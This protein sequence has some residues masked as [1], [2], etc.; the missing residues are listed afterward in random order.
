MNN[1]KT[2]IKTNKEKIL[3]I[4]NTNTKRDKN[5][6]TTISIKEVDCP[7]NYNW[8]N[9]SSKDYGLTCDTCVHNKG[10]Y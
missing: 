1:F 5:G 9:C 8:N 7:V 6:L 4:I 2:F 10:Q 3:K